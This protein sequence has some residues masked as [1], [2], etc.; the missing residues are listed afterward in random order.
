MDDPKTHHWAYILRARCILSCSAALAP[1]PGIRPRITG[2]GDILILRWF[3]SL[4]A[5]ELAL[6]G[7]VWH[8]RVGEGHHPNAIRK[9]LKDTIRHNLHKAMQEAGK[10]P[11]IELMLST[12]QVDLWEYV[13]L[14]IEH[15]GKDYEK[16]WL[17]YFDAVELDLPIIGKEGDAPSREDPQQE[18]W[19]LRFLDALDDYFRKERPLPQEATQVVEMLVAGN[20]PT[21]TPLTEAEEVKACI[22]NLVDQRDAARE[23]AL[24]LLQR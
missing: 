4:R 6:K 12:S 5:L 9:E 11:A 1:E 22:K 24:K 16:K 19:L 23:F 7:V 14:V 13:N 15:V 17:E 18:G 2:G 10:H 8:L 21:G 20:F 3:L